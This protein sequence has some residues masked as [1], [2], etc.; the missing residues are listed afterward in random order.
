MGSLKCIILVVLSLEGTWKGYYISEHGMKGNPEYTGEMASMYPL[1]AT[2]S[3]SDG[4]LTGTM[5]D[6]RTQ[7]ELGIREYRDSTRGMTSL[8]QF[9]I[10]TL[11]GWLRPGLR[12]RQNLAPKSSL[13]GTIN[14][15]TVQFTKNYE[16]EPTWT[17]IHEN[18][19]TTVANTLS[20]P[21][22]YLGQISEDQRS[23]EG[24]WSIP[25]NKLPRKSKKLARGTFRLER[26]D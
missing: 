26:A 16:G 6:L 2:I 15:L 12:I 19:T 22:E 8:L 1:E 21:V 9:L 3:V 25:T 4:N 17:W 11:T 20:Q 14:G 13:T 5:T 7:E 24:E 10:F 23:I 18:G